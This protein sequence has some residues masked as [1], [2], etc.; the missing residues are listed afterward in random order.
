MN[1][2]IPVSPKIEKNY[3]FFGVNGVC[4]SKISEYLIEH[5]NEYNMLTQ[6]LSN[7]TDYINQLKKD[8]HREYEHTI[9]K[10]LYS[11]F[12]QYV[13]PEIHR[14]NCSK[15]NTMKLNNNVIGNKIIIYSHKLIKKSIILN[16]TSL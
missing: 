2:L 13:S 12:K 3:S 7:Y 11:K 9:L 15:L 16:E 5:E 6:F 8:Y 4:C 10:F 1:K 14:N